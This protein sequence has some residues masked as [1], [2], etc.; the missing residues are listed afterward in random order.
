MPKNAVLV[1]AVAGAWWALISCAHSAPVLVGPDPCEAMTAA[2][3]D[4]LAAMLEAGDYPGVAS[5]VSAYE[6]HCRE[7]DCLVDREGCED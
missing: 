6:Q 4:D 7:D 1:L 2:E 3:L 5:I